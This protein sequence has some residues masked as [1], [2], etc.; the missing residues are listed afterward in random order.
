M[1]LVHVGRALQD[2]GA[3]ARRCPIPEWRAALGAG[4]RTIELLRSGRDDGPDLAAPVARV[5]DRLGGARLL[6]ATND[7]RGC[8]RAAE[9]VG[10]SVAQRD[11]RRRIVEIEPA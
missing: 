1:A 6:D 9:C 11:E 7:G 3:L 5:E 8:P 2:G 4:E 10:E